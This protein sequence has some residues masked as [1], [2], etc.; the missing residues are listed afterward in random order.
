M[1]I[2]IFSEKVQPLF[3]A[4]GLDEPQDRLVMF[5]FPSYEEAVKKGQQ[6]LHMSYKKVSVY[7]VG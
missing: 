3:C 1:E 6:L 5:L 4:E 2:Q 7:R